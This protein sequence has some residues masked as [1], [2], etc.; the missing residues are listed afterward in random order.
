MPPPPL[1]LLILLLLLY[2]CFGSAP[3]GDSLDYNEFKNGI[4]AFEALHEELPSAR[5]VEGLVRSLFPDG[6]SEVRVRAHSSFKCA[7]FI[8]ISRG[9]SIKQVN[10][11]IFDRLCTI[12]PASHYPVGSFGEWAGRQLLH[13]RRVRPMSSNFLSFTRRTS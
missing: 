9:R 5:S 6:D 8:S 10:W 3:G 7:S 2:C 13:L 11:E 1:L 4:E 12:Y